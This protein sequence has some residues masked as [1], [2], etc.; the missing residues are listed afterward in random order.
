MTTTNIINVT[1]H[2]ITIVM[3]GATRTFPRTGQVARVSQSET[4]VG[5]IDGIPVTEVVFG[6]PVDIPDPA[7]NTVFIVSRIVAA[8]MPDRDDFVIPG[9]AVRNEE[10]VIIGARGFSRV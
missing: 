9:P 4:I 2:D 1:P 10:G 3:D 8:A 7:P 5:S 6:T